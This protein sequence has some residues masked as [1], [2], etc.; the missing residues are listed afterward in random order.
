MIVNKQCMPATQ[1]DGHPVEIL[2]VSVLTDNQSKQRGHIETFVMHWIYFF[3]WKSPLLTSAES[4]DR[5]WA[6]RTHFLLLLHLDYYYRQCTRKDWITNSENV[7]LISQI[8]LQSYLSG[9]CLPTV[10]ARSYYQQTVVEWASLLLNTLLRP[11]TY[12]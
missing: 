11:T 10:V 3:S 1:Q 8:D 5:I 7:D 9:L 12:E 4:G 6:W 2:A